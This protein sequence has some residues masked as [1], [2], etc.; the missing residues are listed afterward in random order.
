VPDVANPS[1]A[2]H[3][4]NEKVSRRSTRPDLNVSLMSVTPD[5]ED[6]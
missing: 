5:L 1:T 3:P 4:S 2:A 6:V